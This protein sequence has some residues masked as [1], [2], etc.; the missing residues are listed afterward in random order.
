M[1]YCC[2]KFKQN[3]SLDSMIGLNIRVVKFNE[4]D[5]IDKKNRYRFF[6]TPGYK[7]GDRDVPT[8]NIAYCP[9]CGT[10]LFK[11]YANDKYVNEVDDSFLYP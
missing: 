7:L 4:E 8:Y 2:D 1:K 5:L 11:F 3:L 10:N 9:F 6:I